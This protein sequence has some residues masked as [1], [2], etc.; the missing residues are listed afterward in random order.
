MEQR[1]LQLSESLAVQQQELDQWCSG[2][3]QTETQTINDF[4]DNNVNGAAKAPSIKVTASVI[5]VTRS[6]TMWRKLLD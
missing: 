1:K 4:P 3:C 5:T 2:N 6:M